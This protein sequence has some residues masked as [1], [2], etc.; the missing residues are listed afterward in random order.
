MGLQCGVERLYLLHGE[1]AHR[2]VTERWLQM[3]PD[4]DL[5]GDDVLGS[6]RAWHL[7]IQP[8]VEQLAN[9]GLLGGEQGPAIALREGLG[10]GVFGLLLRTEGAD[11][12]SPSLPS[13]GVAYL[14]ADEITRLA[15]RVQAL[16]DA[17]VDSEC[18]ASL[19]PLWPT[20]PDTSRY[21]PTL[22]RF[23]LGSNCRCLRGFL[24]LSSS[25]RYQATDFRK[26]LRSKRSRIRVPRAYHSR[27]DTPDSPLSCPRRKA[28]CFRRVP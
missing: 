10:F 14:D 28:R 3:L 22:L 20:V 21:W 15:V 23:D 4:H 7:H 9:R 27:N 6:D 17:H 18:V 12:Q 1:F 16:G 13:R 24:T 19:W 11:R 26:V 25:I 8:A 2:H 5:V